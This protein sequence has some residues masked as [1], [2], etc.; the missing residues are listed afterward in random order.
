MTIP[1]FAFSHAGLYVF[2]LKTMERFYRKVFGFAVT[3]RGVLRGRDIVFLSRNPREHHEIVLIAGRTGNPADTSLN[4]LSFRVASLADLRRMHRRVSAID[5]VR[6]ISPIDHGNAWAVYFRDPEGNH[7]EMFVDA[8][9][10][11]SQPLAEPLDF[12]LSD[13]AIRARTR[14]RHAGDRSLKPAAAWRRDFR[15]RLASAAKAGPKRKPAR[16]AR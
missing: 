1:R 11:V 2:D 13:R 7:I 9:W 5:G 16:A 12:S 4:Q 10:Y 15:R 6:D 8:P 3:D 14:K